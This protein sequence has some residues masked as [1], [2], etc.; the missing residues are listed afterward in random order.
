[1]FYK[2]NSK[3]FKIFLLIIGLHMILWDFVYANEVTT[4]ST[5]A[6]EITTL[7][8]Q[9]NTNV[10]SNISHP[11]ST[12]SSLS[13]ERDVTTI[14][15]EH[16][17][18]EKQHQHDDSLKVL[19]LDLMIKNKTNLSHDEDDSTMTSST[20]LPMTVNIYGDMKKTVEKPELIESSSGRSNNEHRMMVQ[21]VNNDSDNQT[22][23]PQMIPIVNDETDDEKNHSSD[24]IVEKEGR[25]INFPL[26]I[27]GNNQNST[28][29]NHMQINFVTTSTDKPPAISFFDLSDV[30]MDH[31]DDY[32]DDNSEKK[33]IEYSNSK[34]DKKQVIPKDKIDS[35]KK[36]ECLYNGTSYKVGEQLNK[37]CEERCI[38]QK[39][40][41]WSCEPR[42][43]GALHIRGKLKNLDPHCFERF[44]SDE[45]C[46]IVRCD[47]N[48]D[49]SIVLEGEV[50]QARSSNANTTTDILMSEK[51][52]EKPLFLP[53]M[54]PTSSDSIEHE[55]QSSKFVMCTYKDKVY[56][57]D[58]RIEIGCDEICSCHKNGEMIC[59]LRCA[60]MNMTYSDHCVTVKDTKDPCCEVQLCD[61]SLDDHEQN[62]FI[63]MTGQSREE[64][65]DLEP[66]ECEYKGKKYSLN[67]QFH[68]E[69]DSL[70]FCDTTGVECSKIQCPSTFGLDV[71][72]PHCLKWEP[73]PATFRAIAPKCCP[74]R[75]RCI[76]NGT[77]E[78]KG[79]MFDNWSEIPSNIS[80]CE[81]H[82]FCEGGKV[83]CRPVCPP[84]TA[85][86][87]ASLRCNEK[88]AKLV[89]IDEEDD[90]C[91]QWVCSENSEADK[92]TT[93]SDPAMAINNKD[94][95]NSNNK[96]PH[97]YDKFIPTKMPPSDHENDTSDI[98]SEEDDHKIEVPFYP[99]IDGKPPKT[100]QEKPYKKYHNKETKNKDHSTF[101]PNP[102]YDNKH[103]NVYENHDH[104]EEL[105]PHQP[106]PGFFNPDTS[107]NQ[108]PEISGH[109]H[110]KIPVDKQLFNILGQNPQNLP[111]HIRIDQLLQHIQGQDHPNQGPLLHGQNINI[112]FQPIIPNGIN[113]N[114]F[115]ENRDHI[116]TPGIGFNHIQPNL[117]VLAIDAIDSRRVRVIF[118]VPQIYVGLHGRV[119]LRFTN[120]PNN[121][122]TKRW[123]SQIFAPPDDLIATS[124]LEFELSS[125]EPNSEYRVKITLILRDLPAQPSSQI[126]TVHTPAERT[127]T[128]P[129]IDNYQPTQ[130]IDILDSLEDP[131]LQANEINSTFIKFGWNKIPDDVMQYV[132]GIQL[133]YKELSGKVYDA[134]PLIHRALTS[135]TLDNLKPETTY[136]IGL[137]YI[138]FHGH[139]AE[140]R[141]GERLEVTTSQRINTYGFEVIVNVTKIKP[142]TVEVVWN[143]VPYPEDKYINIFRA[144]YQSDSGKEDSSV[145][146][147]AK[148]DSTTGTLIK[149]LKPGT[150][151]RLWLE[152]YLTNG[153]IKKSNVV[154]FLTK[155]GPPPSTEKLL[156][157]GST[158]QGDYYGPLV[159]V[160]VIAALAVMST[161]ILLL[162]LTRR[163]IQSA[164]IT[165]RKNDVS[166]DNPSYKVEIQQET[167]NL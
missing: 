138:P 57:V 45:C 42:C 156:T 158:S 127:I 148:R 164:T 58:E 68:D 53:T 115:S 41:K 139:G 9:S 152:M 125:L 4:V 84:V 2:I 111:P 130:M 157:A 14:P 137:F 26:E 151:Y 87:P 161:V 102:N 51:L 112:P 123:Q 61:V 92:S 16:Q 23:Q 163:R 37:E 145:F 122:D 85:L 100:Q 124:Q 98:N 1:M 39:G 106:G 35:D 55:N 110:S 67:D 36:I 5:P 107:K 134:T 78:Y 121:N 46:S 20:Q 65:T 153:G 43:Q 79:Q 132:D 89:P 3:F 95:N 75:M 94:S 32:D 17:N 146:K 81:Q 24:A 6:S 33:K 97:D 54:P 155:P 48:G 62:G 21:F 117:E 40:A 135:Y 166:Y 101:I 114:Q 140:L 162:I 18:Q 116:H 76:D 28:E 128:P 59:V 15:S 69:C 29:L 118:V 64:G 147:V 96:K 126:Y 160:G 119:E 141:V 11:T 120:Q 143:G 60:K 113:Y 159:V 104:N 150:R 72:D 56:A 93:P 38:C 10:P 142:T 25:A 133:R 22:N 82:C 103:Y 91:K 149:D 77:C 108:F 131:E 8:L 71:V 74:E 27:L 80:G 99:T 66:M 52:V 7:S 47:S 30:S 34:K 90:C 154:N 44:S 19:P 12:S 13:T 165:P 49:D 73:E 83:E 70:C 144:I 86:P 129:S 105:R 50:N 136:E 31:E 63:P 167:M 88:Y 109:E